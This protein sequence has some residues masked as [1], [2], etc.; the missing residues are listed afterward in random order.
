MIKINYI[1]PKTL[2]Y[3][4]NGK[5]QVG[6]LFE[7][8]FVHRN[9]HEKRFKLDGFLHGDNPNR[10]ETPELELEEKSHWLLGILHN[11]LAEFVVNREN[12]EEYLLQYLFQEENARYSQKRRLAVALTL[13][14]HTKVHVVYLYMDK[15]L[16]SVGHVDI[17]WMT[18]EKRDIADYDLRIHLPFLWN[19]TLQMWNVYRHGDICRVRFVYSPDTNWYDEHMDFFVK[20]AKEIISLG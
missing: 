5:Q 19:E 1:D 20:R 9:N 12:A 10:V 4:K 13:G 7:L 18:P 2:H 16:S 17:R 8:R 15:S 14:E 3:R 6:D 11:E